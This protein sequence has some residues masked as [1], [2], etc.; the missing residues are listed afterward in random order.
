MIIT[1]KKE[2]PF[3]WIFFAIMPWASFAYTWGVVGVAFLFSLK[4]FVENPAGLTFI[5]SLP[6]FVSM[7]MGPCVSFL[8]D[9][10]WT[11][12][13]R[14]KPFIVTSWIGVASCLV[15]M[16]L[17]P[18]FW[19]LLAV[20]MLYSFFFD[21]T[22]PIDPLKLEIIPPHE[23]GRA[24]GALQWC[25]NL[26]N[27]TF[28]F[29]ALGRFDD[30]HF[31]AGVPLSGEKVIYWSAALL[32]TVMLLLIM[33]GIKE[34]DQKSPLR[35]QRLTI[36]N[37]FG[38]VLDRELWPVYMLV[39]GAAALN[40]G[41]GPLGNL[42]YTDQW[43]YTKQEMGINIAAG[44]TIN[45]FIIGLLT[46]FADKLNRMRAYQTLIAISVTL[47]VLYFS[48]VTFLLPNQRPSLI[49][50]I[51]FGE[52]GCIIGL[53]SSMV[54]VPLVYDYIR[55]NKMG[56]Y[57]AGANLVNRVTG[58][59]TL[60][61]VGLF[62]WGYA[63][64]FQP[65]AGEMIRVVVHDAQSQ[66]AELSSL[67]HAAQ[68]INPGT[69]ALVPSTAVVANAWQ[70][71]G[72]VSQSGRGWEIRIRDK[73][74]ETLAAR[75]EELSKERSP[76]LAD[77]KMLRDQI[78][79]HIRK[80]RADSAVACEL[81]ANQKQ[82]RIEALTAQIETIDATLSS[83]SNQF[84]QQVATVLGDRLVLEGEQVL[85]ARP[86]EALVIEITTAKRPAPQLL[87]KILADLRIR[88]PYV[89][90]LRPL[91]LASGYGVAISALAPL[92]ASD[93]DFA[94]TIQ[95]S[96]VITARLRDPDLFFDKGEIIK[97]IY[98]QAL[99]L[100]LMVI[101]DP[102]DTYV[103]PIT[104]GVNLVLG[105]FDAVPRSDRRLTAIARNLRTPDEI[106]HVRVDAGP[107]EK[108]ITVTA[109]LISNGVRVATTNDP[110]S[111]RL[112]TILG[113]GD[114][115]AQARTFYDRIEK[116]AATQ[117]ITI[118]HPLI[119]SG[120]A[121]IKYNY[122]SGY[123]WMFLMG[124]TGIA[125]TIVFGRLESRGFVRKRGVEEEQAS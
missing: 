76:L 27:I 68:W 85:N 90:D 72:T 25:V 75:K 118:A 53:L 48:Y 116:V 73:D 18:N 13:G 87:E 86:R 28:Y 96:F 19:S 31:M 2:I 54:Y 121:P 101:E 91:K 46:L 23:R 66:Q 95:D 114:N 58:F 94:H 26:A 98:Q 74:S 110:V 42:L 69:H 1:C 105:L 120:Y 32:L 52:T 104:R 5:L 83:R 70:A 65:P 78:Q 7:V 33:L 92:K 113:T 82:K 123:L 111:K 3:H 24:T 108:T 102:L 107:S 63:M 79:I 21:L 44:G 34:I 6:S 49:E 22:S 122:M 60:N 37:F 67:L 38:G 56:T 15:L 64:L 81:N 40:S 11:R 117:Q 61:G 4:K 112:Q 99:Q 55:R 59:I 35:G 100:D 93:T 51:V 14:R 106:N 50:I 89:V 71:N 16:P 109:L 115:L 124:I 8:S 9:R 36:K 125:I 12:F 41:L 45:I 20:Y 57:A 88:E 10:I 84:H 80:G 29:V 17:M 62:I 47:N 103:S 30:V 77:E 97:V 43:N 119:A 39:F